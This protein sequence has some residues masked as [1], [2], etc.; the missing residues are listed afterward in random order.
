MNSTSVLASSLALT[1]NASSYAMEVI[2]VTGSYHQ[3]NEQKLAV[4]PVVFSQ[5]TS[6]WL[7][8]V[9]GA[10]INTNGPITGIAQYRG[11]FAERVNINNNGLQLAGA[12]P[13]AM[14]TPLSYAPSV[15]VKH[16]QIYRGIA[17]VSA[18]IDTLGGAIEVTM[19]KAHTQEA[20]W[21]QSNVNLDENDAYKGSLV[22]GFGAESFG[23]M[24]YAEQQYSD[25]QHSA[26]GVIPNSYY[27]RRQFGLLTTFSARQGNVHVNVHKTDT[28]STGTAALPMDIDYI[29]TTKYEL[30]GDHILNNGTLS[31]GL[32]YQDGDH[33]M[34][35]F[36]QR[37]VSSASKE[38]YT[39]ASSKSTGLYAHLESNNWE[40]GYDASLSTHNAD[41]T[42][43]SNPMFFVTNFNEVQ[44]HRHSVFAQYH[45]SKKHLESIIGVRFKANISNANNVSSSM[46]MMMP[47]AALLE[48]RFNNADKNVFT[49]T[50]DVTFNNRYSVNELTSL[51]YAFAVK[52]RAPQYQAR[53]LWLP[54]QST[55][56]LADGRTY[57][58]NIN[59]KAETAYQFNTG[60]YF[61]TGQLTLSPQ[62]F[63]QHVD[64]YVQ[65]T[66]IQDAVVNKVANMMGGHNA[67]Q[68]NNIDAV[69]Y[70]F[71][72]TSHYTINPSWYINANASYVR[73]KRVDGVQDDLYRITPANIQLGLN[74]TNDTLRAQ[75]NWRGYTKQHKVSRYNQELQ[76]PGYGVLDFTTSVDV[77]PSVSIRAG[78]ENVFD[79]AYSEHLSGRN[80]IAQVQTQVGEKLVARGRTVNLG[81]SLLL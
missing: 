46:A 79:K 51:S 16:M 72:V 45:L 22:T 74:Y 3:P 76:S 44:D 35:N 39:R 68:F 77:T 18:G 59:L 80:R 33:G 13:N 40:I 49:G 36:Q 65:G 56:G 63:Y 10:N 37:F 70:G 42:N 57:V 21:A 78:I 43:P 26:T 25:E 15:M 32:A 4:E 30:E 52:Q 73:A 17:P 47:A 75:V 14:D 64:D 60:I 8:G 11:M 24:A 28:S 19:R 58:G 53:Y 62:V 69:L 34:D 6:A 7:K 27:K 29:N 41:I 71:D 67:L 55:G 1:L 20:L 54:M 5:D 9:A 12:G 61:Q 23:A 50:Y 48:Q 81:I 2:T 38:R 66:P 31:W